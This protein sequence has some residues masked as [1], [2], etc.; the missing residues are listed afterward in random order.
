[1]SQGTILLI[2]GYNKSLFKNLLENYLE[3]FPSNVKYVMID[4]DNYVKYTSKKKDYYGSK[5]IKRK[6][7]IDQDSFIKEIQEYLNENQI[8][9][10]FNTSRLIQ[11]KIL[12]DD[13][14]EDDE[15][16]DD[17]DGDD[18]DEDDD[19][20]DG[21]DDD[22]LDINDKR[23]KY[24]YIDQIQ[25]IIDNKLDEDIESISIFLNKE[26]KLFN[27]NLFLCTIRLND[28]NSFTNTFMPFG[29]YL[30]FNYLEC[31][32][33]DSYYNDFIINH[34]LS[35]KKTFKF[36]IQ[37]LNIKYDEK[38][39][40]SM[41]NSILFKNKIKSISII[42]LVFIFH[43][44][45]YLPYYILIITKIKEKKINVKNKTFLYILLLF[46]VALL[47]IPSWMMLFIPEFIN[48]MA[49]YKLYKL[50]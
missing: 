20:D 36:I 30:A 6:E 13:D 27:M 43:L 33:I 7:L 32:L 8:L 45:F 44:L 34:K 15:D 10:I 18:D 48:F 28:I 3:K 29:G 11:Q 1:M 5:G 49:L 38:E 37:T 26:N 50:K 21:D 25:Y 14:D 16:D 9:F 47:I 12:L 23:P 31:L 41:L 39:M 42:L 19:D 40:I 4:I 17:D 35:F 24:V 22:E 46:P 2:D